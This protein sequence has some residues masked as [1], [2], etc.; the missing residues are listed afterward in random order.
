M[1]LRQ[2]KNMQAKLKQMQQQQQQQQQDAGPANFL[3]SF[4]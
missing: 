3:K 1:I 2:L 4:F